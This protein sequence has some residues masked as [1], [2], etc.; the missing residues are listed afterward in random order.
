M[1]NKNDRKLKELGSS[2]DKMALERGRKCLHPEAGSKV[3]TKREYSDRC[4]H[5]PKSARELGRGPCLA[6]FNSR[7]TV[8][9]EV[10]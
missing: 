10:F 8:H 7:G 9:G 1:I 3:D 6:M 2:E 4:Y 5:S